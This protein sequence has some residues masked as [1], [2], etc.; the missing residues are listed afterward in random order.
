MDYLPTQRA[1][2]EFDI[3]L[4]QLADT[5]GRALLLADL[6]K[7]AGHQEINR[8]V[9]D[10]NLSVLLLLAFQTGMGTSL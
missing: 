8:L 3:S 2:L 1:N 10:Q 9:Q 5:R 6:A 4:F 7:T